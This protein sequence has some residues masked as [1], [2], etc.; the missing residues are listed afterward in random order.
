MVSI[1]FLHPVWG[2]QNT[3][4][5]V[6]GNYA[7][8]W[9]SKALSNAAWERDKVETRFA[10]WGQCLW[11]L[12]QKLTSEWWQGAHGAKTWGRAFQKTQPVTVSAPGKRCGQGKNEMWSMWEEGFKKLGE[13]LRACPHF[14]SLD[15]NPRARGSPCRW[16]ILGKC[17]T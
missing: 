14:A 6:S 1:K 16:I 3:K 5:K 7:E 17:W 13:E 10:G 9:R 15:L 11:M 4:T 8:Q 12:I 2:R